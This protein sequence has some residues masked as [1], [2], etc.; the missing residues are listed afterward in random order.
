MKKV[1]YHIVTLLLIIF[2]C[3]SNNEV[4]PCC[5]S[6]PITLTFS[7]NVISFPNA[8]TPNGN[9]INEIYKPFLKLDDPTTIESFEFTVLRKGQIVYS[10]SSEMSNFQFFEPQTELLE[11]HYEIVAEE[12]IFSGVI[13][14]ISLSSE[15]FVIEPS[16]YLLDQF[17]ESL[18]DYREFTAELG[19]PPT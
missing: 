17:D 6:E 4:I 1:H 18:L 8:Y 11:F 7:S 3:N 15:C 12:Q 9:G 5:P 13:D 16:Y 19:C 2:G 14:F 10:E